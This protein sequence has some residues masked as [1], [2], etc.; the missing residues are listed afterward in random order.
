MNNTEST[1][2][3]LPYDTEVPLVDVAALQADLDKAQRQ[4][5]D[6]KSLIADFDNSRK[7]LIQ[8]ADRQ[9]KYAHE[10]LAKDVL[11]AI[12]NLDRAM[13]EAKK[14]GDEGP[15]AKGVQATISLFIDILKRHGVKRMEIAPGTPFDANLHQAVM[16][17]PAEGIEPGAIVQLL[18][19][20]FTIHDRVLRPASVIVAA[21]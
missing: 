17:Q 3:E 11:S 7:R 1:P 2:D 10:P 9:R 15:L 5:A 19:Q 20:G 18:Q 14:A 6:Y 16:Q 13:A 21:E 12:D 8:D 4:I